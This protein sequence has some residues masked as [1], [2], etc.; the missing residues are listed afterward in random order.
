MRLEIKIHKVTVE[1]S[2]ASDGRSSIAVPLSEGIFG[3][4][5]VSNMRILNG[6]VKHDSCIEAK[7]FDEWTPKI[8]DELKRFN[9]TH[10]AAKQNGSIYELN[11][12]MECEGTRKET[13]MLGSDG[14]FQV[15]TVSKPL[16]ASET[17]YLF[18]AMETILEY[19]KSS[20]P[21]TPG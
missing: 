1:P 2:K 13:E 9:E 15:V 21:K 20:S 6:S 16:D 8:I 17:H 5:Y 11:L 4:R 7:R 10:P 12:S 19:L 3:Q 14:K 18:R